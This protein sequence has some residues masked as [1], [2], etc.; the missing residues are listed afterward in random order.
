MKKSNWYLLAA[1]IAV[2]VILRFYKIDKESLWL[3]EAF[4]YFLSKQSIWDHWTFIPSYCTHPPLYY[5]LLKIWV[6]LF[7]DSEYALRSLSAVM[8]A[9]TVPLVYLLGRI[10]GG[11]KEG[12]FVGTVAAIIFALSPL[13]L[14]YAQE[15][16]P[17]AFV[18]FSTTLALCGAFWL[19]LNPREALRP[20]LGFTSPRA[21][22]DYKNDPTF[23]AWLSLIVGSAF[24]LW[25]H[26]TSVLFVAALVMTIFV[27]LVWR[28]KADK[29]LLINS[30]LAG[31]LIIAIWSPFLP[32]LWTQMFG[33]KSEF[34]MKEVTADTVIKVLYL[35]FGIPYVW[36]L[37]VLYFLSIVA[38]TGLYA[39][40]RRSGPQVSLMIAGLI[41]LPI[42]M[43]LIISFTIRPLFLMRTLVWISIPYYIAIA[44]GLSLFRKWRFRVPLMLVVFSLLAMG[45]YKFYEISYKEPWNRIVEHV[46]RNS[47]KDDLVLLL[48]NSV[49]L[50]FLYYADKIKP[51]M[52][53]KSLPDAFPAVNFPNPYPSGNRGVPAITDNDMGGIA[54]LI[55]SS[56]STVWLITRRADLY[57]S[58][59]KVLGLLRNTG[60]L[61]GSWRVSNINI[62]QFGKR[63]RQFG[64]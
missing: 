14:K 62:F 21:L 6:M 13:Q 37:K 42:I 7:G 52:N 47:G 60:G 27:W 1:I 5:T 44:C 23:Y 58:Q 48:P 11:P 12:V 41:L 28:L 15:A 25:F 29:N 18:M 36:G 64:S 32:W 8:N 45:D 39:I 31:L 4:S 30:F 33:V 53:I 19:A 43:E 22:L 17:Y 59:S 55:N 34:W 3:D 35:L 24:S 51:D 46:V 20:A 2:S 9:F 16:R 38:V 57:D 54:E 40:G 49:S 26:N 10:V 63:S 61:K 56:P 50:P